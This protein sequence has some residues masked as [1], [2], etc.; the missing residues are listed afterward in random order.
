[1]RILGVEEKSE[2]NAEKKAR[3]ERECVC[4]RVNKARSY[5]VF[6]FCFSSSL[7][8]PLDTYA[9]LCMYT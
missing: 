4:E 9:S 1:M 3:V 7:P 8:L 6:F 5:R 2:K